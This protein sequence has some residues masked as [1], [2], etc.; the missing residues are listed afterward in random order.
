MALGA[1]LPAAIVDFFDSSQSFSF[2]QSGA[3]ADTILTEGYLI[4]YSRDKFWS[5]VPG[6]SPTGRFVSVEWPTGLQAQAV[7]AGPA[8]GPAKFTIRREDGDIFDLPA[9]SA[10]LLANTSG[11]G[12]AIEIMPKLAGEDG[13]PD[14]VTFA[15]SGVAGNIFSYDTNSPAFLGN[16][17]ALKNFD[18]YDVSLYVDF[19]LVDL[20]VEGAPTVPEA[21]SLGYLCAAALALAANRPRRGGARMA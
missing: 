10:K 21:A 19:A 8:L 4:T 11:A 2:Y 13:F 9:F 16:T 15:A 3:T 17:S 18:T 14:P 20:K 1:P 5:P 7:T 6:G 12:A